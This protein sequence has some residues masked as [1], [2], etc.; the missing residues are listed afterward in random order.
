MIATGASYSKILFIRNAT[1]GNKIHQLSLPLGKISQYTK[2][3]NLQWSYNGNYLS[4]ITPKGIYILKFDGFRYI[5]YIN[6]PTTAT[7]KCLDWKFD[8]HR[9]VY[10]TGENLVIYDCT[11]QSSLPIKTPNIQFKTIFWS[12]SNQLI[13]VSIDNQIA[14]WQIMRQKIENQR[15]HQL[16][17]DDSLGNS[18]ET[19]KV[20]LVLDQNGF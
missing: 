7:V 11:K 8:D 12:G 9:F 17:S 14:L 13:S 10:S 2:I 5:D 19:N 6:I 16:F 20:S 3:S 1:T 15:L 4:T 18:I